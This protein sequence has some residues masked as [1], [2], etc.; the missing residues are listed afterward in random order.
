MATRHALLTSLFAG[1]LLACA[2]ALAQPVEDPFEAIVANPDGAN[3]KRRAR[4]ERDVDFHRGDP[5]VS[6]GYLSPR[7]INRVV[8]INQ[9]AIRYCYEQ[10]LQRQPRL[11]GRVTVGF[12]IGMDGRVRSARIAG[13]S[14]HNRM[15]EGCMV[16]RVRRWQ[17]PLP[18]GGEVVV[19]Y[20][21]F[22]GVS[23]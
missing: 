23:H 8:R 6:N 9:A 17:F 14:L 20:P 4:T 15:V 7:Q 3:T 13:S 16:N 21:F 5:E 10:Q 12:R 19:R 1:A 2:P 18:D 11:A 22:F